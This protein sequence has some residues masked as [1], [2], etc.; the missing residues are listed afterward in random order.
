LSFAAYLRY[1]ESSRP[2]TPTSLFN[3]GSIDA[4][5]FEVVAMRLRRGGQFQTDAEL[6]EPDQGNAETGSRSSSDQSELP[7]FDP[8]I[9]EANIVGA[10]EKNSYNENDYAGPSFSSGS[11][12]AQNGV[13][14]LPK[15]GPSP[16]K[17]TGPGLVPSLVTISPTEGRKIV[18]TSS[19]EFET[20]S[21]N[22]SWSSE[23][24]SADNEMTLEEPLEVQYQRSSLAK[25]PKRS[26]VD[27]MVTNSG[28]G[29]EL[30]TNLPKIYKVHI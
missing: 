7:W 14:S 19:S 4:P 10:L 9:A 28:T 12:G 16:P 26:P 29:V 18:L 13:G 24:I 17:E 30:H 25:A 6:P 23:K 3:V 11:K 1:A 8:D 27:T 15:I 5:S 22:D 20:D 2:P 21:D